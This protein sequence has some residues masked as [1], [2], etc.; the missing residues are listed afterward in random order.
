MFFVSFRGK[1]STKKI[2]GIAEFSK[3]IS[4]VEVLP[5]RLSRQFKK[6]WLQF[7]LEKIELLL[8]AII[9][10]LRKQFAARNSSGHVHVNL[11]WK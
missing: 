2:E 4:K 3:I 7:F 11:S 5:S 9:M 10:I 8:F 6:C 1:Q